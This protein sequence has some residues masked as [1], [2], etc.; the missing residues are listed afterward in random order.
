M[1]NKQ[2][3]SFKNVAPK[4]LF[5]LSLFV[6]GFWSYGR[7]FSYYTFDIIG[8]IY[9]ILWLPMIGLLFFIPILS[10]IQFVR[11]KFNLK[12]L[13]F[14]TLLISLATLVMLI[15]GM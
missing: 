2:D 5:Y 4:I 1:A 15:M 10:L 7:F 14:F 9:E 11:I 12:S 3:Y 6:A 13:Y 8:A